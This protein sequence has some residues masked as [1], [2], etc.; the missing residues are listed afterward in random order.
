ML[1]VV[2]RDRAILLAVDRGHEVL[3]RAGDWVCVLSVRTRWPNLNHSFGVPHA[4]FL[5]FAAVLG[6]AQFAAAALCARLSC[7]VFALRCSKSMEER[8]RW[9]VRLARALA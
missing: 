7:A 9:F 5:G 1:K 2:K 3:R 6:A 8:C 4:L